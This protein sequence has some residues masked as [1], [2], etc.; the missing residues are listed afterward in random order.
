MAVAS[1]YEKDLVMVSMVSSYSNHSAQEKEKI[2]LT[3]STAGEKC[4]NLTE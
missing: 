4:E 1:G 2:T 3:L